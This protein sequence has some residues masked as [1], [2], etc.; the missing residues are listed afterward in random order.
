MATPVP[1]PKQGNTVEECLLASWKKAEGEAVSEGEVIAEIET[2]KATFEVESPASGQLLARFCEEGELVPVMTNICVVGQE[3]EDVSTFRPA[4]EQEG[5]AAP[6][7]EEE[8]KA[9]SEQAAESSAGVSESETSRAVTGTET[10]KREAAGAAPYSPRARRYLRENAFEPAGPV[11]GSGPGGRVMEQDVARAFHEGGRVTPAAA[12]AG[13]AAAPQQGTGVQG[14]VTTADLGAEGAGAPAAS[15]QPLS[16][17]RQKIAS[18]MTESLH[19]AAQY[20]LNS[21][22]D[23]SALLRLRNRIKERREKEDIT[24]VRVSDMVAF[25]VIRTPV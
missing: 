5:A 13:G 4:N 3:G 15:E 10:A 18:R 7:A 12:E 1:M 11:E 14:M 23:V 8:Q 9:A 19:Q 22:A 20:T 24:D 2:D 25:A 17:I 21:C 6:A 16:S